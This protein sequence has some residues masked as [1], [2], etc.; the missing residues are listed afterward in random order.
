MKKIIISVI[1]TAVIF[2]AFAIFVGSVQKVNLG[3]VNAG[4]G[5]RYKQITSSNASSTS[6]TT[7]RGGAGVL[8][9][10]VVASTSAA[11]LR[12]YDNN[13]ASSSA[14]LIATLKASIGENTYVF[15]ANVTSGITLD[16]PAAFNGAYTIT[17]R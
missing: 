3:S 5:Y 17:Y 16:V 11:A 12:V 1:A 6:L 7:V 9:S 4:E 10:I 2:V 13:G 15:D 14:T 8:G